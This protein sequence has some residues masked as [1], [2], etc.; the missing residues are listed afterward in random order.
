MSDTGRKYLNTS[1]KP[2]TQQKAEDEAVIST[3]SCLLHEVTW[4][5]NREQLPFAIGSRE[6]L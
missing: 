1:F 3:R 2:P 4:V 6:G 5:K